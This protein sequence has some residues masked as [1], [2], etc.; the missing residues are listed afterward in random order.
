[1]ARDLTTAGSECRERVGVTHRDCER[2]EFLVVSLAEFLRGRHFEQD[3]LH[4][5]LHRRHRDAVLLAVVLQRLDL[6][7]ARDQQKRHEIEPGDRAHLHVGARL[8]PQGDQVRQADGADIDRAGND[9]VIDLR[10]PAERRPV[11]LDVAEPLKLRMLLDQLLVFHDDELDVGQAVLLADLDLVHLGGGRRRKRGERSESQSG[12]EE[13]FH[14]RP[15]EIG[16]ICFGS[17]VSQ[18]L[19]PTSKISSGGAVTRSRTP[20][21]ATT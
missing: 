17:K 7:I 12:S 3:R 5:D 21:D 1:M 8:L 14:F 6:R 2:I 4:G 10:G 18:A 11:H 20:S 16:V 9:P 19:S 15:H 13:T